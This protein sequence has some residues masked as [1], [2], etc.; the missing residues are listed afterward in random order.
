MF[1]LLFGKLSKK[2]IIKLKFMKNMLLYAVDLR[3]KGWSS[4]WLKKC[5]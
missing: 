5:L 2:A 1:L 3:K 4:I